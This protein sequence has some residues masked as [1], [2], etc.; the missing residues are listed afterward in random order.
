MCTAIVLSI[1]S[2]IICQESHSHQCIIDENTEEN[3]KKLLDIQ[4]ERE[5]KK[6]AFIKESLK[7]HFENNQK[8]DFENCS[9]SN[10]G[11]ESNNLSNWNASGCIEVV[12]NGNDIYG[13]FP[14]T[15]T[16]NGGTHSLKLGSDESPCL[17]NMVSRAI[18]VPLEGKTFINIHF[19]VDIFNFP[20]NEFSAAKFLFNLYDESMAELNCPKYRAFFSSE[21]GP[22]GVP[23]LLETLEPA[24]TI[25]PGVLGDH[26]YNSNVSYSDW[27]HI[28][29]DLSQYAGSTVLLVFSNQWCGPGVD[30]IYN[31]LDVDCPVNLA[32]PELNCIKESEIQLCAPLGVEAEYSWYHEGE[33]LESTSTCIDALAVGN[34]T[35][36]FL[37]TYLECSNNHYTVDFAVSSEPEAD[38]LMNENN[39]NEGY[40]NLQLTDLSSQDVNEWE[41]SFGNGEFDNA[42]NPEYSYLSSGIYNVELIVYNEYGCTDT[43]VQQLRIDPDIF[44]YVPNTF[45]PNKD[46]YNQAFEPSISGSK[47]NRNKFQLEIYDRW[48]NRVFSTQDYNVKWKGE[49]NSKENP[50]GSY[51]WKIRL[52][53]DGEWRTYVG[54][55]NLLR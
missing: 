50:Q 38:F 43:A 51:T 21:T 30:W 29:L 8:N 40:A 19:T 37:P 28:T 9:E 11:F 41:W 12:N 35:L 36:E 49:T 14:R 20:H 54:L 17:D 48:G 39:F 7:K 1:N 52:E 33:L 27:H 31:Y 53:M 32:E 47:F 22:V 2:S 42:Q 25:N 10:W 18:D 46:E 23:N 5:L 3:C 45:T 13:E 4:L 16:E 6:K 15:Y 24:E 26:T 44:V 55:V 34:Y